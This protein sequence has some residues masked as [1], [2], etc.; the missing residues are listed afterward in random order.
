MEP[1]VFDGW[2]SLFLRNWAYTK[3]LTLSDGAG[4]GVETFRS[5]TTDGYHIQVA[6]D[7]TIIVFGDK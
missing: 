3:K 4:D 1:K 5:W 2:I 7:L 6:E